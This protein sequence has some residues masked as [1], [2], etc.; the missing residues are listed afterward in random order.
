MILYCV[1]IQNKRVDFLKT[2]YSKR[3]FIDITRSTLI[4]G[5]LLTF[6]SVYF[7]LTRSVFNIYVF[8]F[9]CFYYVFVLEHWKSHGMAEGWKRS[10]ISIFRFNTVSPSRH[11]RIIR[12][13]LERMR[14]FSFCLKSWCVLCFNMLSKSNVQFRRKT[15]KF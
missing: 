4:L 13:C 7:S 15:R 8:I 3:K 6:Q 1:T 11:L 5:F 9:L 12:S 14:H 10:I 2:L